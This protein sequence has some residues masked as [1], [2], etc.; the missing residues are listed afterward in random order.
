MPNTNTHVLS[1]IRVLDFT[2]NLAGPSCTRMLVEM[3]AEVIKVEQAPFGDRTR[4]A[5]DGPGRSL[6]FVQQ[7]RGKKSV[8]VNF[9]DPKGI[10]LIE[11]LIPHCDVVMESFRPGVFAEMGFGY[12]QVEQIKP[13][14][15]LCSLSAL[16]QT[17][18]LAHKPGYDYIAQ[19]Y[20][21][22][23]SMIGEPGEAPYIPCVGLGD[24]STGVHA[25]LA[26]VAALRHRDQT[27]EG[28]HLDVSLL[29]AYYHYH[30]LNVN[31]YS[32]SGGKI[33]PT[34]NGRHMTYLCPAGVFR[35]KDGDLV[36]MAHG[37]HWKDLCRAMDRNDLITDERYKNDRARL[38]IK[39]EVVALIESWLQRFD[40]RDSAVEYLERFDIPVGPVLSVAETVS[41]PHLRARR[42]VRT[43]KDD[44][45]GE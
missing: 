24:V 7:N 40:D 36:M 33:K 11:Q 10:A 1:G 30:E 44:V 17:G 34:R 4:G 12:E 2:R 21:G 8:C 9:R 37:Q 26:I 18:P 27:G 43:I 15:I 35:T 22:V 45:L 25:A 41:H 42:T 31:T 28:Q 5:A 6:L 16:G 3:G 20:A 13:D 14:I 29:D 23:T 38:A 39:D 32:A 19:A